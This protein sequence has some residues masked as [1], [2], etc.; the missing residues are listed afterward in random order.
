MYN[1]PFIRQTRESNIEATQRDDHDLQK[2]Q[3]AIRHPRH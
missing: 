1:N 3:E 2:M